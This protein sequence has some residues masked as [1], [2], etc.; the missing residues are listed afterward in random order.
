MD[1]V[2]ISSEEKF[3]VTI[4]S[5]GKPTLTAI[6][7]REDNQ[8]RQEWVIGRHCNICQKF[9]YHSDE[10]DAKGNRFCR[11]CWVWPTNTRTLTKTQATP[12]TE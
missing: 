9:T 11:L 7:V 1:P 3:P 2:I 12:N 6:L 4:T 8:S 10:V 5:K